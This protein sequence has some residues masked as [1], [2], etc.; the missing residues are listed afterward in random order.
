M[1]APL[2][3]RDREC[4]ARWVA[5]LLERPD[6]L[7][8]G[9]ETVQA[10]LVRTVGC[11]A[12]PTGRRVFVKSMGFPR[13]KDRLRYLVR[14]LPAR[15]EARML[16][17]VAAAGIPCPQVVAAAGRRLLGVPMASVLVTAALPVADRAVD[18]GER[19]RLVGELVAAGVFH[20]DLHPENVVALEDGGTAVLD[21]QSARFRGGALGRRDLRAMVVKLVAAASDRPTETRALVQSGLLTEDAMVEAIAA[22]EQV[23]RLDL[24]RR[25]LRCIR[26]STEFRARRHLLGVLHER[27]GPRPQ[28]T[29]VR[30][31][32]EMVLLWLGDRSLQVLEGRA[33]V[34][35][36]LFRRSWW[37]PG[38]HSVYIPGPSGAETL[39]RAKPALLAGEQ[40]FR[41]LRNPPQT[42][43]SAV[44]PGPDRE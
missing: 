32:S 15:H 2:E 9:I 24:E 41:S 43:L 6:R 37:F 22:A 16:A 4:V 13:A 42:T 33:P 38:T 27:R 1:S 7:P 44:Q 39:E 8:H 5:A 23:E 19:A 18:P 11:G 34:L 14:T 10:R 29:W 31:G 21:L 35:H 20:P 40:R 36:A 12:L 30:G 25:V 28:G 17:T 3:T 26:T